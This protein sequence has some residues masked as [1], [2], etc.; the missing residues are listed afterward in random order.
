MRQDQRHVPTHPPPDPQGGDAGLYEVLAAALG[1][2]SNALTDAEMQE[3]LAELDSLD[4]TPEQKA[5][6]IHTLWQ[7]VQSLVRIQFGFDPALDALS[8]NNNAP[9]ASR[10]SMVGSADKTNTDFSAAARGENERP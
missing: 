7:I 2:Q 1:A 4:A 10:P 6:L 3:Y 8:D 5:E 9:G